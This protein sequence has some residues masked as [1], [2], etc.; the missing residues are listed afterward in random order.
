MLRGSSP[1]RGASQSCRNATAPPWNSPQQV[2]WS[3]VPCGGDSAP[4]RRCKGRFSAPDRPAC[5]AFAL[6]EKVGRRARRGGGAPPPPRHANRPAIP[7]VSA[8]RRGGARR[9]SSARHGGARL[10]AHLGRRRPPEGAAAAVTRRGSA[11]PRATPRHHVCTRPDV[12]HARGVRVVQRSVAALAGDAPPG[13]GRRCLRAPAR[14]PGA[15]GGAKVQN[16]CRSKGFWGIQWR[17]RSGAAVRGAAA[18]QSWAVGAR[19][20]GAAATGRFGRHS[21]RGATPGAFGGSAPWAGGFGINYK[22]SCWPNPHEPQ[23][24][25]GPASPCLGHIQLRSNTTVVTLSLLL[26]RTLSACLHV[27]SQAQGKV[28]IYFDLLSSVMVV[29]CARRST[30][31]KFAIENYLRCLFMGQ[32]VKW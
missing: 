31:D 10:R 4:P 1:G 32:V 17:G 13:V 21:R 19:R 22:H 14:L 29:R 27:C 2:S 11:V 18:L 7:R 15:A 6:P 3:A 28:R 8:R 20:R 9:G 23:P 12:S 25:W 24:L 5:H 16:D 26:A 30:R